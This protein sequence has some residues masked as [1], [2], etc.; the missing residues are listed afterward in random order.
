MTHQS[1]AQQKPL[2]V[3]AGR[4]VAQLRGVLLLVQQMAGRKSNADGEDAMLDEGARLSSAYGHA[5]PIERRRFEAL[6]NQTAAWAAA[7][8]EALLAY[9]D[10]PEPP[11]VAAAA[12]A[13]E[14]ERAIGDLRK[15]LRA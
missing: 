11:R 4:Q 7:G 12:L 14:L 6:A 5:F 15:I 13:H 2:Q 9:Q 3:E 10:A 8:V 1:P